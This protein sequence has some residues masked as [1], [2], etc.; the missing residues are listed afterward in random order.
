MLARVQFTRDRPRAEPPGRHTADPA[1]SHR[2]FHA[3]PSGRKV[4]PTPAIE[5]GPLFAGRQKAGGIN[6]RGHQ[7]DAKTRKGSFLKKLKYLI[8]V[9]LNIR[10]KLQFIY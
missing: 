1:R 5:T 10:V 4:S 3:K 6:Q 2:I 9:K 8:L 7:K